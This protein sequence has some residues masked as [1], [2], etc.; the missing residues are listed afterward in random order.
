MVIID[1]I[2]IFVIQICILLT[3]IGILLSVS[4]AINSLLSFFRP[5]R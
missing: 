5:F 3:I 4:R 2:S 1:I